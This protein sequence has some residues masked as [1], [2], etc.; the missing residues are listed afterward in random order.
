MK[1]S[2]TGS[3]NSAGNPIYVENSGDLDECNGIIGP[4]PEFPEGIYHYHM[5]I[6]SDSDNGQKVK[7][8]IN[9]S[10]YIR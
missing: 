7:Y 8:F 9:I 1:S 4:T 6:K 2:Y 3:I 5:T 10:D